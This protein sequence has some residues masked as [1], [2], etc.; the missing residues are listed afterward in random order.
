VLGGA[1]CL[2]EP[3]TPIELAGGVLIV[4][5]VYISQRRAR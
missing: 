1:A 5:S 4:L 2:A 3:V